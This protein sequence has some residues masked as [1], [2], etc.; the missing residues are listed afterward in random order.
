MAY[1]MIVDDDQ[2]FSAAATMVLKAMGHEVQVEQTTDRALACMQERP[3]DLVILD[4]MFPEDSSAGFKV[5]REMRQEYSKLSGIPVL[6]LSAINNRFPIGFSRKD[7]DEDCLPID[8]FLD[9][10]V[11]FNTLARRVSDLLAKSE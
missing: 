1:I 3:P 2:D 11:D 6:V 8:D 9:K 7:I 10:P 5:A 4:V